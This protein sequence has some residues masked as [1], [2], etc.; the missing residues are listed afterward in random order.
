M[1][2]NYSQLLVAKERRSY[3]FASL[4]SAMAALFMFYKLLENDLYLKIMNYFW[5]ALVISLLILGNIVHGYFAFKS[6]NSLGDES[7]IDEIKAVK[8]TYYKSLIVNFLTPYMFLIVL[9]IVMKELAIAMIASLL[10]LL[11]IMVCYFFDLKPIMK[12]KK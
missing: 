8:R 1:K 3:L 2:D 7:G 9:F 4:C 10:F 11:M 6:F 5:F 12:L